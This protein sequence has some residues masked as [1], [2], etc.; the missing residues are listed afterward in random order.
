MDV[1]TKKLHLIEKL[2]QVEDSDVLERVKALLESEES[3]QSAFDLKGYKISD[4][5][6][7]NRANEAN[8][9]IERGEYKR[10]SQLRKETKSW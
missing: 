6:L 10:V 4:E 1:Q 8:E 9:A 5:S 7:Q 2:L 3:D